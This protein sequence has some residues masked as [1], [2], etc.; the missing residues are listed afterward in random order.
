MRWLASL[1]RRQAPAASSKA[2]GAFLAMRKRSGRGFLSFEAYAM[3]HLS[4]AAP[5]SLLLHKAAAT[6]TSH[7][8]AA[9]FK[10]C[11]AVCG[12]HSLGCSPLNHVADGVT[13]T[14][15]IQGA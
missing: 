1:S 5:P 2:L 14:G 11:F 15:T 13:R 12:T 7:T 9:A 8:A 3:I 6:V 10:D 4:A